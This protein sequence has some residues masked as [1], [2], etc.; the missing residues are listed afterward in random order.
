MSINTFVNCING[1]LAK[2]NSSKVRSFASKTCSLK[3]SSFTRSLVRRDYICETT[4]R[5]VFGIATAYAASFLSADSTRLLLVVCNSRFLNRGLI[6]ECLNTEYVHM[7]HVPLQSEVLTHIIY[8][9][10]D[11]VGLWSD[12]L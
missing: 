8:T 9:K 12:S 2:V 6:W 3:R 10:R 1:T 11:D 5:I 4:F 7:S